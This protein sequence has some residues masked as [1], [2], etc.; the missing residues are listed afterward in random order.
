MLKRLAILG[1]GSALVGSMLAA[2]ALGSAALGDGDRAAK[3]HDHDGRRPLVGARGLY[4]KADGPLPDSCIPPR[5]VPR[6]ADTFGCPNVVIVAP[7]LPPRPM[8][9]VEPG[10]RVSIQFFHDR[11]L[12]DRPRRVR[13]HL[14]RVSGN[15]D[16]WQS[17]QIATLEASRTA[18][19][20]HWRFRLPHNLHGGNVLSVHAGMQPGGYAH[21]F[22]GLKP[23]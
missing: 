17:H 21:Y 13:A 5:H 8:L 9:P 19:H 22:V 20:W 10:A 1:A 6:S 15:G 11:H 18:G 4:I 2:V 7:L 3:A 16:Q 12:R 23:G 14:I